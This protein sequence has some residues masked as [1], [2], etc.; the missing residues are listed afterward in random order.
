MTEMTNTTEDKRKITGRHVLLMLGAFFGVIIIANV[1][2]I[3]L[4]VRSFPGESEKKSYMQGLQYN[5]V[6]RD[7]KSQAA[8]G[9]QVAIVR[10]ERIGDGGALEVRVRDEAGTVLP[11]LEISGVLKRPTYQDADMALAFS[12]STTGT[13][14]AQTY[15]LTSG[16]WDLHA[17]A[18]NRSGNR[19]EFTARIIIE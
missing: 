8:L 17:E 11:F 19:F 1:T 12:P 15:E 7:R 5:D 2:F 18:L 10:A 9:W 14:I 3:T 6:L 13:Y 4:A 16:I